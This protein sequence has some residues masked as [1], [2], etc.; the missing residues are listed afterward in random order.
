M[1]FESATNKTEVSTTLVLAAM[2]GAVAWYLATGIAVNP[3]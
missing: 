1:M 3:L 2:P